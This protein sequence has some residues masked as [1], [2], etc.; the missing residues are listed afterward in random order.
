VFGLAAPR[1]LSIMSFSCLDSL[2]PVID[3]P[4]GSSTC[5]SVV[6]SITMSISTSSLSV[7]SDVASPPPVRSVGGSSSGGG[8]ARHVRGNGLSPEPGST[9][10][11]AISLES[12]EVSSKAPNVWELEHVK[13]LGTGKTDWGWKC[14]WCNQTF[15][16]WNATKCL[17]HLAKVVGKDIRICKSGQDKKHKA[18]YYSM[19]SHKDKHLV[20]FKAREAK[21]QA[22]VADGQQSLAVMLEASRER[23]SKACG[24][25]NAKKPATFKE[26]TVEASMS[27]Q[28]TMA[29]AD[30]VHSNGLPFWTTQGEHFKSI[31]KFA[32]CV[33]ASYSPPTRNALSTNL[34]KINYDRRIQR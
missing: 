20:G 24:A 29:I 3:S 30:F 22:V 12:D 19:L 34:L 15:K 13:K 2:L 10:V 6:S 31:L 21:F 18:L 8:V 9:A 32:R 11:E 27:S 4:L 33:P 5:S 25:A 23:V 16:S 7:R 14:L 1:F 17:Y 26:Q 28:L